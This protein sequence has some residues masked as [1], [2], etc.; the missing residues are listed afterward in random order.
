MMIV[1]LPLPE[2]LTQMER[3]F[4]LTAWADFPPQSL[5]CNILEI[6]LS[7]TTRQTLPVCSLS[8]SLTASSATTQ[9]AAA[10]TAGLKPACESHINQE[11][12]V[13]MVSDAVLV[14]ISLSD[15]SD[16]PPH[17][18]HRFLSTSSSLTSLPFAPPQPPNF[19][20]L[21]LNPFLALIF[22][23][24]SFPGFFFS[25]LLE[26]VYFVQQLPHRAV[27]QFELRLWGN[28]LSDR[29]KKKN[30]GGRITARLL[31]RSRVFPSV[32]CSPALNRL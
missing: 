1:R 21:F 26:R 29:E 13:H 15:Q 6:T 31:I 2:Q 25:L 4:F 30:G 12:A 24:P 5:G 16:P 22:F 9:T 14:L 17:H 3:F 19:F 27:L 28:A 23:L 10:L 11:D 7:R 20:P 18:R 32:S 8:S